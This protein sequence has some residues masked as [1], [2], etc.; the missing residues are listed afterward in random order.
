MRRLSLLAAVLML[1]GCGDDGVGPKDSINVTTEL[2]AASFK[3]GDALTVRVTAR[4]VGA[5]VLRLNNG[6]LSMWFEVLRGGDTVAPGN[7]VCAAILS[8]EDVQPGKSYTAT[9]VWHGETY[10][11]SNHT[12]L[13]APGSYTV[14]A[15]VPYGDGGV[16]SDLGVPVTITP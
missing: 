13:L 6:C 16:A 7:V 15:T 9:L 4:N 1:L 11:A 5:N 12:V 10:E 2:S 3:A 8:Y 14:R